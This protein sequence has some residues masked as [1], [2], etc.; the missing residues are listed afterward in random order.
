MDT[1]LRYY[2]HIDPDTLTDQQWAETIKQLQHIRQAESG[3]R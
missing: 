1:M 2:L 3:Q